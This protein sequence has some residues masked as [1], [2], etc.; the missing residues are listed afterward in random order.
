[1][2]K[3][4]PEPD[5]PA[6]TVSR[7]AGRSGDAQL[8]EY[9]RGRN[10]ALRDELVIRYRPL[11]LRV[12]AR[13][14]GRLPD[15]VERA[16][17]VSVGMLG[18]FEALERFDPDRGR[19][20][21]KYAIARVKGAILD[22]LRAWGGMPRSYWVRRRTVGKVAASLGHTLGRH[23]APGEVSAATG[24]S[25][26]EVREASFG[27]VAD[28]A[29]LDS[30]TCDDAVRLGLPAPGDPE[31]SAVD[32]DV[33]HRLLVA[34]DRLPPRVHRVIDWYYREELT[35][36]QIAERLGVTETRVNQLHAYAL[37]EL[38]RRL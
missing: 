17:L 1:M 18:L 37:R 32:A 21:E 34:V 35:F 4:I 22:E 20:F 31:Q 16:D 38:R 12:A 11:V 6:P 24:M 33:R 14:G 27:P 23:P 28:P 2:T 8:A 26:A 10:P 9:A 30:L 5:G 36:A 25:V 29:V 15:H 19:P 3:R 7:G 13:V